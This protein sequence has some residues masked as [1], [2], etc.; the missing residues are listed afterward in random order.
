MTDDD[1]CFITFENI[2]FPATLL[3]L[4]L[5]YRTVVVAGRL[6]IVTGDH[7]LMLTAA[8]AATATA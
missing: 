1:E 6:L 8:A 7:L 3:H 2:F 4:C 5:S